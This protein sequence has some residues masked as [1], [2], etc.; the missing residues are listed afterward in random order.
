MMSPGSPL[1]TVAM[2]VLML[3]MMGGMLAGAGWAV[4]SHRRHRR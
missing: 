1:L 3:L 2:A 4:L